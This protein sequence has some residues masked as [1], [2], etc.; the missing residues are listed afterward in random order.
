MHRILLIAGILG[1]GIPAL[2]QTAPSAQAQSNSLPTF[3]ESVVVSATLETE[4]REDVPASVTVVDSDEIEA[5]QAQTLEEVLATVPGVRVA[6]TGSAGQQTSVFIRGAESDQVLLLWNGLPLNSAYFGEINWQFVPTDGVERVEVVRGPFSALYGSNAVGGV[7]QVFTGA[8][9]GG[10]LS[11]EAGQND[12]L[13]GGLAAGYD[14]GDR[15]HF[16]VTGHVRRGEG[17]LPNDSFDSEELVA[18]STWTLRP[19]TTLGLLVRGNDSKVGIPL[20]GVTPTL[21]RHIDWQEREVALPFRSRQG[22]WEIEAQLSRT[23][24]DSA[25]RDPDSS[26]SASDTEA[27]ALRGRAV[28]TYRFGPEAWVAVGSDVERLEVTA[29]SNFGQDLDAADQRTWAVF[30]QASYGFGPL[31]LEAG[32]RRDDNDAF[33]GKN[34]L[35]GGAVWK[36]TEHARLRASYGEAFRAPSIGELFFPGSGN[37]DLQ[38]ETVRSVEVGFEQEA[39]PWSFS[40]AGFENRQRNLIS[41]DFV[42]FRN[43]NIGRAKSR[44]VEAEVGVRQGIFLARLSG[45]YLDTE[46]LDTGL[47]LLRRP[48]ESAALVLTAR[49]GDWT[50]NLEGRYVGERADV[51]PVTF[52]RTGNPSYVRLDAAAR[53]RMLDWLAPYARLENAADKEY[54]EVLGFPTPGR[55]FVGG[56]AVDF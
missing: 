28:A 33:G 40:L 13:R 5:R 47:E 35:R 11:L 19:G 52:G 23:D 30:G 43:V 15:V 51:D 6:Q 8:Q 9:Q 29:G 22:P 38:P 20:S 2:A 41:F 54:Q 49:P 16:D 34:S 55:T 42:D 32:I 14:L 27:E 37:P 46:D 4:D 7:V 21:R 44:G 31:R 53:W 36:L 56:L 12:R 26:F 1:G 25:F 24:F 39:G 50:F 45:T 3:E 48:K 17:E 10:H 18:R